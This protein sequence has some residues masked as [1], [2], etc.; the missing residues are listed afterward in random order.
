[1]VNM[2]LRSYRDSTKKVKINEENNMGVVFEKSKPPSSI[3]R[4]ELKTTL[5]PKPIIK[6]V[7]CGLEKYAA[8][9]KTISKLPLM[10]GKCPSIPY[11][12]ITVMSRSQNSLILTPSMDINKIQHLL[13]KHSFLDY[14]GLKSS[15]AQFEALYGTCL[16]PITSKEIMSFQ[17]LFFETKKRTE[18]IIFV[19]NT[20]GEHK[21]SHIVRP[22]A[23]PQVFRDIVEK[24]FFLFP[25][26][27]KKN[28]IN[29]AASI[30]EIICNGEPFSKVIQYVN[31]YMDIKE[32][33]TINNLIKIYALLTT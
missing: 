6:K 3:K 10:L 23:T 17:D 16:E 5:I 27:D 28:S 1:M 19:L 22:G 11:H 21:F 32:H 14:I 4:A 12:T 24:Y 15:I 30:V 9:F 25:P 29:F 31:A 26:K 33:T 20:I 2:K 18:D 7:V 13:L 8:I